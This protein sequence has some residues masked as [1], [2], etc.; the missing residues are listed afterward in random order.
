MN[1]FRYRYTPVALA[2]FVAAGW[3]LQQEVTSESFI[4][5]NAVVDV[6]NGA[7]IIRDQYLAFYLNDQKV[8]YSRF[9]LQEES[10][11][12]DEQTGI[13]PHYDFQSESFWKITAM[14]LPFEL[15]IQHSGEVDKDLSLRSFRFNFTSSG[16][17]INQIGFVDEEGLHVTTKSE[18]ST[19]KQVM[20]IEGEVY[21]TDIIPLLVAQEGLEV[22][23]SYTFP[24]YDPLT[25]SFG[26]ISA[27]VEENETIE[28]ADGTRVNTHR[29]QMEM[30]GFQATSW[31]DEEGVVYKEV[32]RVAGMQ[33]TALRESG[34]EAT[35][36]DFVS[37][38]LEA[39]QSG[40][41]AVTSDLVES[42]QIVPDVQFRN[43]NQVA[44]MTAEIVGAT[45]SDLSFPESDY[46]DLVTVNGET[47]VIR[48]QRQDYEG[49][50]ARLANNPPP[51]THEDEALQ[52]Y[53][54]DD[55]LV[56]ASSP[57][58][59]EKAAEIADGA[60]N[61]WLASE[62]IAQWLYRN[63]SKE[64]RVTI[65]SAVE[66]LNSMKGDCNE[67]A[68]LFAAM[69]RSIGIPTKIAAGLVYQDGVFA[70]HAWN[71]VYVDGQWLP[72][73]A[74][75]NRIRM[76]AAYVKLAEGALDSQAGLSRLIGNI[77]L[78]IED[79]SLL[80]G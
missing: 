1:V 32:S 15:R 58:I 64:F 70:Y 51:Y 74:T 20:P 76:D 36:M 71:E 79:Y 9:V 40:E 42:S 75:L 37:P 52:I 73:D 44:S 27:S 72:I 63:I 43:P 33:M 55:A 3:F 12:S 21:S 56:Q 14:G 19:N 18:D 7:L 35:D 8:G 28:L 22:G 17:E 54:Q 31:V 65:P 57:R 11:E 41:N 50:L 16:Q 47:I 4:T 60:P 80:E 61:A 23:T 77:D 59:R 5:R 53:L 67:H 46:Q 30:Q 10:E 38:N 49:V 62:A 45:V 6:T 25:L 34:E 78:T 26:D 68:T 13:P 66:V 24:I 48:T 69:A 29:I 39:A 2:V